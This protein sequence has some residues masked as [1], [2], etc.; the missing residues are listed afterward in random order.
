MK[1]MFLRD[2]RMRLKFCPKRLKVERIRRQFNYD[3]LLEWA[4]VETLFISYP[5]LRKILK[6]CEKGF[7]LRGHY[8]KWNFGNLFIGCKNFTPEIRAEI[9]ADIPK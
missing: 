4:V 1:T 9:R 7:Y 5:S 2:L 6:P 8:V 3:A